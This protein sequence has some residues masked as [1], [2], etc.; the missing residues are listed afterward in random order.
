[1]TT[2]LDAAL[3]TTDENGVVHIG[4]SRYKVIHLASEH[5]S[6]GWTAEELLRQHPDLRPE[7]VYAALAHFYLNYEAIVGEMEVSA[8]RVEALRRPAPL[9][10][11]ELL[12]RNV[13][14]RP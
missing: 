8:S 1:M 4:N 5:Y 14:H 2:A 3:L 13:A 11:D 9:S 6:Y 12:R 7:E 10:R